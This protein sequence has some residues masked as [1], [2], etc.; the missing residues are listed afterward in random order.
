MGYGLALYGRDQQR[1]EQ[2]VRHLPVEEVHSVAGLRHHRRMV[3]ACGVV[4]HA[5]VPR[6]RAAED[7][8]MR[9]RGRK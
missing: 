8:E 3:S 6:P 7:M 5:L 1:R 4:L 9:Q 2:H